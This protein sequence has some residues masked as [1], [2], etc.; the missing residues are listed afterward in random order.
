MI[1]A[2]GPCV[3]LSGGIGGAKLAL[4][5]AKTLDPV[6]LLVVA[7]T[8]VQARNDKRRIRCPAGNYDFSALLKCFDDRLS[9]D[10]NVGALDLIQIR[11]EFF[12]SVHVFK[13][14]AAVD[15]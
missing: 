6:N 9:A 5:L 3:A 15:Q 1:S 2:R 13:F 14:F 4:G 7:N 8:V 10:V 12:T 11:R